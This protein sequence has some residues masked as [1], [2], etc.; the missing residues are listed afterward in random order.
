[1]TETK[2]QTFK[3]RPYLKGIA[4]LALMFGAVTVISGGNVLF[5]A[6]EVRQ[7]AGQIVPFVVWFNFIAGFFYI[8]AGLAIWRGHRLASGLSIAIA[9]STA[10][11]ATAFG[12]WVLQGGGYEMRTVGSLTLRFVVWAVISWAVFHARPRP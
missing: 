11:V 10:L 4:L 9:V 3:P 6:Q 12:A 2:A 8:A 1:M 5:G 7:L